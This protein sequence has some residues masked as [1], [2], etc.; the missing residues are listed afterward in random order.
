MRHASPFTLRSA[1]IGM[2]MACAA[3]CNTR[4]TPTPAS[5][6]LPV[7]TAASATA[8]A[9]PAPAPAPEEVPTFGPEELAPEGSHPEALFAIE[10]ALMVVEGQRIGQIVGEHIEWV[11]QKIPAGSACCGASI[12]QSVHGTWPDSL[13]VVYTTSTGRALMPTY[14]PLTGKGVSKTVAPGGGWGSILGVATV[15]ES[16]VIAGSSYADGTQIW[17]VRG[18]RAPHR[19][20]TPAQAGCKEDEVPKAEL[21][22]QRPAITPSAFA[23][24]LAGTL[25]SIGNLCEK[26][27]AAAEVWDRA[28]KSRILAL[29]AWTK[30]DGSGARILPGTGDELWIFLEGA[31]PLLRYHDGEITQLPRLEKPVRNVFVSASGQLHASDGA[32]IHRYVDGAWTPVVRLTW[33]SRFATIALAGHRLWTASHGSVQ[34][35][36][37]SPSVAFREGCPTPFVYLYDVSWKNDARFTF[38]DTRKALSTFAEASDL[39]LVEFQ[40]GVRRLGVVVTSKAQGE[41]VIAHVKASMKDEDPQ[42]LCYEPRA[43]RRIDLKLKGK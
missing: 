11:T 35:L 2:A 21:M 34:Q 31:S 24:S 15:G 28:G 9:T 40:E 8:S 30:G 20:E 33:P 42:L 5:E 6:S 3:S 23:A 18:P 25:M 39:G 32:T 7:A 14:F 26:R 12:V 36:R 22:P 1:T 37:P 38:P 29:G 4:P 13:D 16:T 17:T 41:A 10:G 43:P 27:G 19:M